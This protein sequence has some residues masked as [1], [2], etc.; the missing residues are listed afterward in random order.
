MSN[1]GCN[2]S[3][4]AETTGFDAAPGVHVICTRTA[5]AIR[6]TMVASRA[7]NPRAERTGDEAKTFV[8]RAISDHPVPP[9]FAAEGNGPPPV[10][11][12]ASNP[13]RVERVAIRGR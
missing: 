13:I 10:N 3:S 6:V 4:F 1:S 12:V 5:H 9:A 2:A 11:P 8:Q 7:R